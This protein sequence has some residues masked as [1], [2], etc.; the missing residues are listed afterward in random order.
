MLLPDELDNSELPYFRPIFSQDGWSCGQASSI[1]YNFTYEI[2][3]VR[4]LPADTNINQYPSHFAFNFYNH[5]EY[6]Q[7]VGYHHTFDV[8]KSAGTPNVYDYEGLSN[9]YLHWMSD[10]EKYYN[11]M[12][13]KLIE[14]YAIDV[15]DEEGIITLKHWMNDHLNGSEH[16]GL[17]NFYTDLLGYNELPEGT[18]EEGKKVITQ[19]GA[20]NGHAMTL[21]G[22]NDSIRWDYNDDGQFTNDLDINDDGFINVKDWEVGGFILAN[23]YGA[24]W[25]DSG[26][27]Y[28]MAKVLQKKKVTAEFGIKQFMLLM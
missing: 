3:R 16:G 20:Y 7:G 25:C 24:A 28:V 8:L 17:A 2:D 12:Y 15:S 19:F 10:Y 11:G 9:G 18:P 21:V 26:L 27:C 14:V 6:S 22:W 23:S 5:G 4:D 13:N 1:G